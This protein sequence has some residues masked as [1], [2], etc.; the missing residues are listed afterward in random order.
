MYTLI[1]FFLLET[2]IPASPKIIPAIEVVAIEVL[3]SLPP[4]LACVTFLIG[5]AGTNGVQGIDVFPGFGVGILFLVN[6]HFPTNFT[7]ALFIIIFSLSYPLNVQVP[8]STFTLVFSGWVGITSLPFY[9][10]VSFRGL[11]LFKS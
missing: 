9:F 11:N 6:S 10:K 8:S 4:F 1:Y 3:A 2:T 7:S 5:C